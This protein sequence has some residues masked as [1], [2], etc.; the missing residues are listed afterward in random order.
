M[1]RRF[2]ALIAFAGLGGCAQTEFAAQATKKLD[3]PATARGQ[4][5]Y[6]IGNPYQVD[7]TWYYPAEDFGYD[8]TGIASWYGQDFHGKSTAN[9]ERYDMNDLT[10]AH[11]TLPLPSIVRVTNLDNGRS[12]VVRVNDRGPF[13]RGRVIDLSRRSAQ[14]LGIHAPGTAKVRVQILGDESRQAKI[15]ALSGARGAAVSV[16]TASFDASEQ[17]PLVPVSL[18][19]LSPPPLLPPPLVKQETVRPTGIFV[20]A[21]SFVRQDNA[22]RLRG[23][24]DR[25]GP[26]MVTA[27]KVG[28]QDFYRVRIGPLAS[29]DDADRVLD[30]VVGTG[31]AEAKII[32]E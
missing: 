21:G 23:Q 31:H 22:Q 15:A 8:E 29:V 27:V 25:F 1:V 9:G 14:L 6:K 18:P 4:G 19:A 30:R 11:K 17:P 20:Q 24:L 16:A 12:L 5:A 10:A 2:A 32:V 28:A 13:V 7:G 3:A 26:A